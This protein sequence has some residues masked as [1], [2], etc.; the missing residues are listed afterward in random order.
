[1]SPILFVLLMNSISTH[2]WDEVSVKFRNLKMLSLLVAADVALL[3][4]SVH[5]LQQALG[6]FT[7]EY[8]AAGMR[9]TTLKLEVLK[10]LPKVL[11][12]TDGKM[13]REMDR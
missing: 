8:E 4:S 12:G 1:M 10:L 11:R 5:N 9:V 3:A 13:E 6:R 2:C 7:T